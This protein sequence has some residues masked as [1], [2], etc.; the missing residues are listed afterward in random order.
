MPIRHCPKAARLEIHALGHEKPKFT[1]SSRQSSPC[2]C[3]LSS[4]TPLAAG[5]RSTCCRGW[6]VLLLYRRR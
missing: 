5:T 6:A 2:S 1:H 3:P 4:S